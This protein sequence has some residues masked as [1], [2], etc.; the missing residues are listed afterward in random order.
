MPVADYGVWKAKPVSYTYQTKKDDPVSPHLSLIFTDGRPGQARAA[1]N[2]KSG[3]HS[4][5]RLVYWLSRPFENPIVHKLE[6]LDSGFHLLKG[7]DEQRLG[8]VA[9]DY[10]RGNLFQTQTGRLLPHDIPGEDNDILD[11]LRPLLDQA[12]SN[13]ATIYVYGSHFNDGKGIHNVHMN[14]GSPRRWERDNGIYQDGGFILQ[15]KDHWEAVFIGFASQ[16]VHTKDNPPR[17][18]NPIPQNSY[19]TWADFL[20]PEVRDEQRMLDELASTPVIINQALVNP[21]G[22][23]NQPE[24]KRETVSLINRTEQAVD[25]TGWKVRNKV[26]Q[27]E[28][29]PSGATLLAK[30]SK[31][32]EIP[33]CP[34]SNQGGL[35]TLLNAEG[36]KVHGVSYTK[37]QTKQEGG[38]VSFNL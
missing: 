17:A 37:A 29:L 15:F 23:D 3:D 13:E 14:Q 11:V 38:V 30:E 19:K 16:A 28:E 31:V 27:F 35:I 33:H 7:T 8:G 22:P 25:L 26:G 18:G 9:L 24:S 1:I 6:K 5:S 2:I 21:L 34:L 36:L 12:I 32:F 10:I 20:D 4:D